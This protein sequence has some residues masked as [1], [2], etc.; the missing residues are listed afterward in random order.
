[1]VRFVVRDKYTDWSDTLDHYR[2]RGA[3]DG[4]KNIV[5]NLICFKF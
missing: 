2:E 5:L 3:A 1:M 4:I